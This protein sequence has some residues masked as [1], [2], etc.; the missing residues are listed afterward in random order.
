MVATS[1]VVVVHSPSHVQLFSTPWTAACRASLSLT[2]SR[3]LPKFTFIAS[4]RLSSHLILW[5]PLLLLPSIFPSIRNFSNESSVLI[6]WPEYWSFSFSPSS[7]YSRLISLKIDRFDL[8]AV[9]ESFRTLVQHHSSKASILWRSAFFTVWLS[10]PYVTTG[11]SHHSLDYMDLCWQSNVS[12]FQHTICHRFPAKKQSS[13]DFMAAVT[14]CSDFRAHEGEICHYFHFFP[15]HLPWSNGAMATS[16]A[17]TIKAAYSEQC[18]RLPQLSSSRSLTSGPAFPHTGRCFTQISWPAYSC[19]QMLSP[20]FHLCSAYTFLL[21]SFPRS[22]W[23]HPSLTSPFFQNRPSCILCLLPTTQIRALPP[24]FASTTIHP[25]LSSPCAI[26]S[27]R[28]S[29]DAHRPSHP[30]LLGGDV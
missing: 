15:F 16:I 27:S 20:A 19:P 21:L 6:R 8:L 1:T 18:A 5:H 30:P 17:I 10:Q 11:K 3:S 26:S 25:G 4:L 13:S 28:S 24:V 12:A 22:L 7:E 14:V 23:F 9:Q 29:V 2:I